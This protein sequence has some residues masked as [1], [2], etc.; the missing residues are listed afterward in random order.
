[1]KAAP[2]PV[3]E[4]A[5]EASAR[6]LAEAN[7]AIAN[8]DTTVKLIRPF[9]ELQAGMQRFDTLTTGK[10][11]DRVTFVLD[12]RAVLTKKKPPFSVELDLGNLPR[13]RSLVAKAYNASGAEVASDE[14][15]VNAAPN[16]FQVRLVEPRR[17][18]RYSN[19]LLA[20]AE[21]QAPDGGVVERVEF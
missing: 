13:P 15:V 11:I 18:K 8:G 6:M 16:R 17:G 21:P 1:D 9:G 19:S 12:G 4:D 5:D 7:A 10:D 14:M 2:A 3:S 20:K